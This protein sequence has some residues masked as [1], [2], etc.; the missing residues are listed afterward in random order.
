MFSPDVFRT[1]F[2]EALKKA[3]S[4]ITKPLIYH[5]DGNY[6]AVLDDIIEIGANAIHPIEK[7]SMDSAW[8]VEQYGKKLAMVGNIDI[9]YVLYNAP[10]EVVDQEVRD[11]IELF[12]PG[13]GFVICDSNSIPSFCSPQN[14]IEMSNAVKKYRDIY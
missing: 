7:K 9:D 2:K 10:A 5:S 8:L 3:A 13:G 11:C 1:Y 6:S 12:G 14:V 4:P